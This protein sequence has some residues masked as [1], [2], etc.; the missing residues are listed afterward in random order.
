MTVTLP[1]VRATSDRP[2]KPLALE[3]RPR[4]RLP[5]SEPAAAAVTTTL[6]ELPAT[7]EAVAPVRPRET[8]EAVVARSS[9]SW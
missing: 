8:F 3:V 4:L 2:A 7:I 5:A 6:A 1:A 9:L